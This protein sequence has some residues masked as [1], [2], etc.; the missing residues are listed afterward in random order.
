M[1]SSCFFFFFMNSLSA[2]IYIFNAWFWSISK[3]ESY[4]VLFVFMKSKMLS[5]RNKTVLSPPT[6]SL[7]HS[8]RSPTSPLLPFVYRECELRGMEAKVVY[9]G[10][11]V[12]V[13]LCVVGVY[14]LTGRMHGNLLGRFLSSLFFF[15]FY[16]QGG[17]ILLVISLVSP[18]SC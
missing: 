4:G 15:F 5:S 2:I 11:S 3:M 18:V 9:L 1:L 7:I 12:R 16:G 8:T 14:R 6:H 17:V 13:R 10:Q